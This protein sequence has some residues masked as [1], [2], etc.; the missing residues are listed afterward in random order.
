V[1][2][3]VR[4]I[5]HY[6]KGEPLE[7][8]P[9][10]LSYR[11]GKF[12]RRNRKAVAA[13]VIVVSV[14]AAQAAVF[15]VRLARARNAALAEAARTQRIQR[16]M[17]NL[18]DGGQHEAGPAE[19]LRVTALLDRGVQEA[20][21]LSGDPRVQAELYQTLGGIYEKLGKFDQADSLLR[22]ALRRQRS[23][24]GPAS[25]EAA[26]DLVALGFLRSQLCY[27]PPPNLKIQGLDLVAEEMESVVIECLWQ[28][29]GR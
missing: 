8:R 19:N 4:D 16:F 23:I 26:E 13:A 18:F 22:S 11:I 27:T 24:S 29:F 9:D 17:L 20:R 3:L 15:T 25:A 14:V 28:S 1:E 12:V 7:A 6:L 10:T 2:A 5:G 21:T